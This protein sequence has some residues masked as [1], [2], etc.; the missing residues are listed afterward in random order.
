MSVDDSVHDRP[1]LRESPRL[2]QEAFDAAL[3]DILRKRR[4]LEAIQLVCQTKGLSL[5]EAL[6]YVGDLNRQFHLGL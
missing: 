2:S 5:T 3:V 6:A 4:V 1:T